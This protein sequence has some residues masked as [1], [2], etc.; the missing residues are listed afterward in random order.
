[1]KAWEENPR[2]ARWVA[3]EGLRAEG[4]SM[5]DVRTDSSVATK[6]AGHAFVAGAVVRSSTGHSVSFL[7]T[8]AVFAFIVLLWAPV[9]AIFMS[10]SVVV[11]LGKITSAAS[12]VVEIGKLGEMG[13]IPVVQSDEAGIVAM[14]INDLLDLLARLSSAAGAVAGGDLAVTVTGKGDLPDA[15]R[16][17]I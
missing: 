11:P 15:F 3:E 2:V 17:M 8:I 7:K 1:E 12:Q 14:H 6:R 9:C 4:A 13:R 5:V 16:D 10:R